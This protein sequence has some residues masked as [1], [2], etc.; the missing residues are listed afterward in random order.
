MQYKK[1]QFMNI[2]P[3]LQVSKAQQPTNTKNRMFQPNRQNISFGSAKSD[4]AMRLLDRTIDTLISGSDFNIANKMRFHSILDE[5]LPSIMKPENF[6]NKGRES[7]VY[8]ISDRYVA[9]IRRGHYEK[10]SISIFDQT[11]LPNKHFKDLDFYYG[12]PVAK[13][14]NVEIL[15]NATPTKNN[16]HCGA[17][18]HYDGSSSPEELKEYEEIFL[19]AC[20]EVPQ[21]SFDNLAANLKRLNKKTTT[22][23]IVKEKSYYYPEGKLCLPRIKKQTYVPDIVNP[24][25]LLISDGRFKLVDKLEKVPFKEPNSIYTMLEPLLIRITPETTASRKAKLTKTRKNIFKKI[26]IASEKNELPLDSPIKYEFSDWVLNDVLGVSDDVLSKLKA[27]RS[28]RVP[29]KSR[30]E[31]INEMLKD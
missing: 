18:F 22:G 26:L 17:K 27:M 7:K 11:Q 2:T 21:E 6:I 3:I 31:K 25:N 9:K 24:N 14:G 13:V 30:I 1:E 28:D 4:R 10:N 16:I 15:K 29:L 8:R 5:A 19:P 23:I 12:E 20:S